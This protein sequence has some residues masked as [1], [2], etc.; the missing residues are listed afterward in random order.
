MV[1]M[2]KLTIAI[3]VFGILLLA[4]AVYLAYV[5]ASKFNEITLLKNV[6]YTILA[7]GFSMILYALYKAHRE[8]FCLRKAIPACNDS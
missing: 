6:T 1:N 8:G 2:E 3:M 7:I 5:A 4:L